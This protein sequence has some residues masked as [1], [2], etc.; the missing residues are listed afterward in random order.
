MYLLIK[1]IGNIKGRKIVF[2]S[3]NIIVKF[4]NFLIMVFF[5]CVELYCCYLV[6]LFCISDDIVYVVLFFFLIRIICYK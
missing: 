2:F 3:V 6:F 5:L 4:L 1:N